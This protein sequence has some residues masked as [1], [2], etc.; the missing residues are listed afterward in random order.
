MNLKTFPTGR[1]IDNL[2]IIKIL[3]DDFLKPKDF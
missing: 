2:P 1:I 3:I